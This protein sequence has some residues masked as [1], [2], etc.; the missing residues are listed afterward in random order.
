MKKDDIYK[1]REER[2][3]YIISKY[4]DFL[5]GSVLDVGCDQRFLKRYLND[6]VK[7]VG[8]DVAGD[9]DIFVNLD[10]EKIPF[11]D[12]FFDCVVCADVL[13]HL[14]N[15]HSVF[16]ELMRVSKKYIIISLPNCYNLNFKEI[17]SCKGG[18]KFYGLPVNPPKDRHRWFFNYTEGK[19]FIEERAKI[20][21][22]NFIQTDPL[23]RKKV[24]RN[25]ILKI[26]YKKRY[27]DIIASYSWTL[28]K[29]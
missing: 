21:G 25:F 11:P 8:I 2:A 18:L 19:R 6:G 5:K 10:K 24:L 26:L 16:D 7:Y 20:K 27:N 14:D 4:K 17:I 29:K 9:P 15:I 12:N 13:E 23:I 1:N 3:E 28:I 22:A